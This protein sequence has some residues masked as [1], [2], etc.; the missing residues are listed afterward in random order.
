MKSS[1][2]GSTA[3]KNRRGFGC[4]SQGTIS[5]GFF[6]FKF[7]AHDDYEKAYDCVRKVGNEALTENGG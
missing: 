3:P 4:R 1:M 5:L 7:L 6:V 2:V